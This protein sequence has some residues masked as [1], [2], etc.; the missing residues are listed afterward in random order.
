VEP[1]AL[2]ID[3]GGTLDADGEPWVD[4][5]FAGYRRAGGSADRV[6]FGSAF[7][8]SDTELATL[9]GI[10]G[11]DYSTT[12]A[13]QGHLL[14]G[15]LPDG[16]CL[17]KARVM[18][19]FVA[20]ARVVA[21][22]NREVLLALSSGFRLAVVS[23]YQGNLQPGLDEL[24]LG[25]LFDVVSDSE[26]VGARKP[27]RRIFDITLARLGCEAEASWMI[28]DS[29]PNDIAAATALGMRTCWVAPAARAGIGT[30][31]T[32][33]VTGLDQLPGVLAACTV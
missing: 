20:A 13:A 24:G 21:Q 8:R 22:R 33:R 6:T 32:A 15:L 30:A 31:P 26:V 29:P 4:R 1:S 9:P 27:D 18:L 5:F 10:A 12:V 3:F 2:L 28:G 16:G 23:N 19:D 7:A 25:D 17:R 14:A 11:F